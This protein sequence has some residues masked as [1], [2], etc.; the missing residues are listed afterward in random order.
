MLGAPL[1]GGDFFG[2]DF[3]ARIAGHFL[4]VAMV[5]AVSANDRAVPGFSFEGF[6]TAEF[7]RGRRVRSEQDEFAL[8]AGD[9]EKILVG[10]Q[11][12][13]APAVAAFF[14]NAFAVGEVDASEQARVETE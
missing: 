2:S 13:L 6:E 12:D 14:P 9:E 5:D 3:G 7:A 10:K 1:T 8:F 4:G 11:N